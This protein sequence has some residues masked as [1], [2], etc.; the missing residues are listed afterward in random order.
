MISGWRISKLKYADP[1]AAAFDGEGAKR[2]G[3]RWSGPGRRVAYA[4]SSL[5]LA[6]LEYFVNL[7]P[8]D[9]PAGLVSIQ[10]EIPDGV[11]VERL[12]AAEL[13]P[14]W[15]SR[16]YPVALHAIGAR[17][18]DARASV[19]LAV[20]SVVIPQES[21]LLVNPTHPDFSKLIFQ[22]PLTFQFDP[23]MWK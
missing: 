19:C 23:R 18:F 7:D 8:A 16:P 13:P 21:N 15:M 10:L 5:A 11:R 1:P 6:S 22:A 3:G 20:P 4:S 14:D 9:Q 12:T 17:W 2:R